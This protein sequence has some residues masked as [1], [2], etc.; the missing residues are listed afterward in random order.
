MS[1]IDTKGVGMGEFVSMTSKEFRNLVTN[2]ISPFKKPV[3]MP[4]KNKYHNEKTERDGFVYDSKKEANRGDILNELQKNGKIMSL[5][6]Q[7]PFILIEPFNYRGKAIRGVKWVA[8]FYYYD[9]DKKSWVAEDVKSQMTKKKP[10]YVIKKKL[11]MT[12]YPDIEFLEFI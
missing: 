5:E 8:D 10:E 1:Y 2:N 4:K 12:K 6:R 7:K 3:L 11:F 9:C